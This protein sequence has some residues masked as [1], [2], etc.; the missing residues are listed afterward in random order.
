MSAAA[1]V[2][3][4]D[5]DVLPP[6][7]EG[8]HEPEYKRPIDV[9]LG[10]GV[11]HGLKVPLLAVLVLD[12]DI[13]AQFTAPVGVQQLAPRTSREAHLPRPAERGDRFA[14]L[15][16]DLEKIRAAL[17]MDLETQRGDVGRDDGSRVVRAEGGL[18]RDLAVLVYG[19]RRA[20]RQPEG[21][22]KDDAA[23]DGRDDESFSHLMCHAGRPTSAGLIVVG[24]LYRDSLSGA[25]GEFKPQ[26]EWGATK[27]PNGQKKPPRL[28]RERKRDFA[29]AC[30]HHLCD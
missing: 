1:E 9:L 19:P 27:S 13:E 23:S 4:V 7:V 16:M 22:R 8:L 17:L 21:R 6:V 11:G 24:T 20:G 28:M 30:G 25:G 15:R 5:A 26:R 29:G 18:A 12:V 14:A 2:P 3:L 10:D